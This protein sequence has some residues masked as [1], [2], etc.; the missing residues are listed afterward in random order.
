MSGCASLLDP[1]PENWWRSA[2]IKQIVPASDVKSDVHTDCIEASAASA[3]TYVAI[4]FY[5]IGRSP[6]R[7]AFPIPSADAVHV[8]DTVTVNSVLCKLKVPTK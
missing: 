1:S 2:E 8:G 4:V 6:Y 3:P 7:Q 5:R